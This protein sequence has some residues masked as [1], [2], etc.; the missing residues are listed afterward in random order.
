[1][2]NKVADEFIVYRDFRT[3]NPRALLDIVWAYATAQVYHPCMF[4]KVA[5]EIVAYNQLKT[6]KPRE[7]SSIV[8]RN[9]QRKKCHVLDSLTKWLM[10]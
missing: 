7:L 9:L 10:N 1:M 6:V 8:C 4:D 3:S 5:G 2:F